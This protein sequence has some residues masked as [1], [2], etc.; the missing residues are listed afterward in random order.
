MQQFL[1]LF[2]WRMPPAIQKGVGKKKEEKGIPEYQWLYT[3]QF[4]LLI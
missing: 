2:V 4:I 1:Y 3:I